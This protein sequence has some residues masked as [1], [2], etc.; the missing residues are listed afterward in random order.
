MSD[1][2]QNIENN[3]PIDNPDLDNDTIVDDPPE[4]NESEQKALNLGWKQKD[5]WEGDIDD[6][7]NAKRFLQTRDIIESNKN[8]RSQMDKMGNEFSNR[9]DGLQKF[10]EQSLNAKVNELKKKRD[11]AASEADMDTYN[12]ANKQLD[13]IQDQPTHTNQPQAQNQKQIIE[14]LIAHPTTQSFLQENPWFEQNSAKGVYGQKVFTDWLKANINNQDAKL[15]D[16]FDMVRQSVN[17][18][19]KQVNQNRENASSMGNKGN[20][21]RSNKKSHSITMNSLT[22]EEK[23]IWSATGSAWDSQ[24]DF[25]Q[26]VADSRKGE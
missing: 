2:A 7:T 25:L 5:E 17:R 19:F 22:A 10:H 16:G 24:E 1:A 26:A 11:D 23:G 18:E 9:I 15:E 20:N 14:N 13:E 6:W 21:L 8:L 12:D 3:E 4:I